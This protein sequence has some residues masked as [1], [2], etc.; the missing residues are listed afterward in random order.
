MQAHNRTLEV[1][2]VSSRA[3]LPKAVQPNVSAQFNLHVSSGTIPVK[4]RAESANGSHWVTVATYPIEAV[5]FVHEAKH[6]RALAEAFT[7]LAERLGY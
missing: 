2:P 4:A 3:P 1:E 7:Q 5:I 6:A